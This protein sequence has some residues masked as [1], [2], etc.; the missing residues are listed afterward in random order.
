[1]LNLQNIKTILVI[2]DKQEYIEYLAKYSEY[3]DDASLVIDSESFN[4]IKTEEHE[5]WKGIFEMNGKFF[6]RTDSRKDFT[7]Y[8]ATPSRHITTGSYGVKSDD[9]VTIRDFMPIPTNFYFKK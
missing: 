1:M 9:F 8:A 2:K 6:R 3:L 5:I 7:L 4:S